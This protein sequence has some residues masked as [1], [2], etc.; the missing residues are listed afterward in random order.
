MEVTIPRG[1]FSGVDSSSTMITIGHFHPQGTE[2]KPLTTCRLSHGPRTIHLRWDVQDR[3]VRAVHKG[4]QSSVWKDSCVEFFVQPKPDSGYFNFETNCG[5]ELLLRYIKDP[6]RDEHDVV[7]NVRDVKAEEVKDVKIESALHVPFASKG[8][9]PIHWWLRLSIP[10]DFMQ[11]YVG[12]LGDLSGQ[13]WR[14]NFFKCGD[15]TPMPHFGSWAS[16][17]EK[18]E[19]H[20]PDKFGAIVFE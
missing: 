1:E 5:G 11:N 7:M 10:I 4:F 9:E 12:P 6:W 3:Y 18:L 2:H 20:Q 17:G 13:T 14:A 16:I 19:F 15:A 8:D